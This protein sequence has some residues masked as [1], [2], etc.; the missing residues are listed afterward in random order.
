LKEDTPIFIICNEGTVEEAVK[1]IYKAMSNKKKTP[2]NLV[3]FCTTNFMNLMF[4]SHLKDY[5]QQRKA[6]KVDHVKVDIYVEEKED[7]QD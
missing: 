1:Q 2:V 6:K 7:T 5:L 3:Y 4:L